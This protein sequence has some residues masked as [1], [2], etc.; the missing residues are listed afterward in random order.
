MMKNSLKKV[1][2]SV[3]AMLLMVGVAS[4]A[5]AVEP[6]STM[7]KSE[8]RALI[9]TANTRQDHHRLALYI[10]QKAANIIGAAKTTAL[11]VHHQF[12]R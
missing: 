2:L 10:T 4:L 12:L 3:G 11:D 7:T 1:A 6:A 5:V 9:A 8:A